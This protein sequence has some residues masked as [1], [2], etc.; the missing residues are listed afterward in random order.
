MS[1]LRPHPPELKERGY[2]LY[3][4]G[5]SNPA[6]AAELG[7][8]LSTINRWSSKEKWKLRRQFASR[9]GS[10]LGALAPTNQDILDEISQLTFEEKQT[11]YDEM[12]SEEALRVAYAVRS[13]P[14]QALLANAD[15][16]KKLDETAR[17]ALK[18]EEDK[19]KTLINIALLSHGTV[20]RV[21]NLSAAPALTNEDQTGLE[22]AAEPAE[23]AAGIAAKPSP[24]TPLPAPPIAPGAGL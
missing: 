20:E 11:R 22:P 14:P 19:P 18:L 5:K 21:R 6:I 3:E 16:I 13:L 12:M 15:K 2:R 7:I 4:Q 24:P 10:E 17:K 9:P 1:T 8:P 23:D